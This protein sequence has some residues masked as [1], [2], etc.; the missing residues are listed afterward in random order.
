[1]LTDRPDLNAT[2]LVAWLPTMSS[3]PWDETR[4]AWRNAGWM[5]LMHPGVGAALAKWLDT[6]AASNA[7]DEEHGDCTEESCTLTA[8]LTVA[9]QI[10][11]TTS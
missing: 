8:A 7:G 6:E 10:L 4:N 9:R 3:N 2:E 5:A 1:M 11:G